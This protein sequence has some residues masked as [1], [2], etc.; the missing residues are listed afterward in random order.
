[1]HQ[2]DHPIYKVSK[3]GRI[4]KCRKGFLLLGCWSAVMCLF[5]IPINKPLTNL[6]MAVALL[7][8]LVGPD[9]ARRLRFALTHPVALGALLWWAVLALSALNAPQ[10]VALWRSWLGMLALSYPL[11]VL[12]L[13]GDDDRWR[14]RA[15]WSFGA[16]AGIIVLISWGQLM[17]LIPQ[18]NF[19]DG[20]GVMRNVVF[21]DYTQQGLV[22]LCLASLLFSVAIWRRN[23]PSTKYLWAGIA[24]CLSSVLFAIESRT[25]WL[26]MISLIILW[27]ALVF[28]KGSW[29]KKLAWIIALAASFAF[30]SAW[31]SAQQNQ[32][33]VTQLG[34]EIQA[35]QHD[36]QASSAGI[37]LELWRQSFALIQRAPFLGHGFD[38]WHPQFTALTREE[39]AY[40]AYRMRFPH[41]EFL[42][43]MTEQGLVGFVLYVCL[44]VALAWYISRL[45]MPYSHYYAAVL[46]LYVTAGMVNSLLADFSHRH[47]LLVWLGFVPWAAAPQKDA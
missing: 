34:Q 44:L 40:D 37:R 17:G 4:E 35:Q 30:G 41:Q 7:A 3:L 1:M 9:L 38:Q 31:W 36:R 45:S 12:S 43:I 46:M 14:S 47:L 2:Q 13:I 21:K 23:E 32:S 25:A 29:G 8:T 10:S 19:S 42:L 15:W 27:C 5:F 26:C 16:A 33:R 39:P 24:V 11:L 18:R 28:Y 6:C 22:T 20:A